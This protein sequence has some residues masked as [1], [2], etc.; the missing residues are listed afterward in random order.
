[1]KFIHFF[2]V[3]F[4]TVTGLSLGTTRKTP[5]LSVFSQV[6]GTVGI[7]QDD[8]DGRGPESWAIM[9]EEGYLKD[10]LL[11]AARHYLDIER[12]YGFFKEPIKINDGGTELDLIA[13]AVQSGKE[14]DKRLKNS[15]GESRMT[16]GR[17]A[18]V[19]APGYEFARSS[20]FTENQLRRM[21]AAAGHDLND[22]TGI[23]GKWINSVELLKAHE[24]PIAPT[25]NESESPQPSEEP[26]KQKQDTAAVPAHPKTT[27]HD[28]SQN[29][30]ANTVVTILLVFL[31]FVIMSALAILQ[32]RRKK[33]NDLGNP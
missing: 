13:L 16:A 30:K 22:Y 9:I 33:K 23:E 31:G 17:M 29:P 4:F 24:N 26:G 3:A 15:D 21:L 8:H 11:V 18:I 1:M 32:R 2:W 5:P 14:G 10:E 25:I 7:F 20:H 28:G 19:L 12:R 27:P 6:A